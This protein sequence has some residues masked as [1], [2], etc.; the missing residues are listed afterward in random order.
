MVDANNQWIVVVSNSLAVTLE[1]KRFKGKITI[2]YEH[3]VSA[4]LALS[5][6]MLRVLGS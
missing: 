4:T 5:M 6:C 1:G 3:T 2:V